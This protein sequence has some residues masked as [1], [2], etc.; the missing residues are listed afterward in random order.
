MISMG[1]LI[2]ALVLTLV[3]T[4]FNRKALTH[5]TPRRSRSRSSANALSEIIR[6]M[7]GTIDC[8]WQYH[9]RTHRLPGG[10]PALLFI[11]LSKL[12][13]ASTIHFRPLRSG[14]RPDGRRTCIRRHMYIIWLVR[15]EATLL[16]LGA[17]GAAFVV[18]KPKN[19]L[20][21]FCGVV[22]V[23]SDRRLFADPVQDA[24]AGA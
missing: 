18:L 4:H 6:E 17:I 16:F 21:L 23:W 5:T 14:P 9:N 1:V 19:P 11:I 24:V 13:K 7:G 10:L 22:V 12:H 15:Q 8:D 3:Y 2:I 20:A